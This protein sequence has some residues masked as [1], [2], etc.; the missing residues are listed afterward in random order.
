MLCLMCQEENWL[1]IQNF[2][3]LNVLKVLD[4]GD[5]VLFFI[6]VNVAHLVLHIYML[7]TFP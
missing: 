4:S 6:L 1:D 2:K 3:K 7:S 5:F